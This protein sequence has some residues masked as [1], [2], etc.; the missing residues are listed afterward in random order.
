MN[1]KNIKILMTGE[2]GQ[3]IQT[4][5]KIFSETCFLEKYKICYM[6]HYGVEMRM[7]ISMAYVQV[8]ESP[9]SYPKFNKAD[10][11]LCLTSRDLSLTKSYCDSNTIIINMMNFRQYLIDNKISSKSLNMVSLGIL[12]KEFNR[13]MSLKI[14]DIVNSIKIFLG[15]KK[16]IVENINAFYAGMEARENLYN[17]SLDRYPNVNLNDEIIDN[18]KKKYV[19]SPNHCKGCGLC[20]EKC[21]V[22][23]LSWSSNK[24]NYFGNPVPE[25]DIEKCI[26][27]GICEDICP[28]MA[29]KVSKK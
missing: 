22:G 12:A 17:I 3:G 18:D 16:G 9:V 19:H 6:P 5:A 1:K 26:S 8:S 27:C 10:I 7:G 20:I 21:P 25:V 4:I 11:I 13:K 14:E 24:V 2:G 28:D 23:A 29:I 15:E